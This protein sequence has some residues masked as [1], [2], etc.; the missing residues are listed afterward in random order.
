MTTGEPAMP[1]YD[2]RPR[3]RTLV[4]AIG[5]LLLVSFGIQV[6]RDRGWQPYRPE[7]SVLWVRSGTAAAKLSLGYKNLL[8]D[9]YWMRAVVY[10]GAKRRGGGERPNYDQLFPLLDLVTSLDPHFHVAYRFGAV[11][12][13]EAY[14]NGPGRPDLA[15]ELLQ[16]GIAR[17]AGRWTYYHDAGFICYWSLN[18]LPR[19]AEWF[20][21]GGDRP[22]AP[23]W[24]KPLA[25]V[26]LAEGGSRDSS[27]RLFNELR[28][29]DIPYIR[30]NAE[31]RL[32]QLDVMD[33]VDAL[34]PALKRFTERVGR[35]PL[36]I[37]EFAR[38]ERL[39]GLPTD[40]TGTPLIIDAAAGRI[41]VSTESPL[42]PLPVEPARKFKP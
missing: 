28:N 41:D 32:Q 22:G 13:S 17:D 30:T 31:R 35:L 24:L 25:A 7:N 42:W 2:A 8:A 27:R 1:S 39:P 4:A 37:E 16:R 20:A 36:D 3:N 26:T 15:L 5:V 38:E 21:Q 14:P 19:A 9:I 12:L 34:T 29:S 23:E 10:Y 6:I 18:D 11:F 33:R 40:S